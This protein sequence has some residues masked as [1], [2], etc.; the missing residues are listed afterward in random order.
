[1]Q[2]LAFG[3]FLVLAKVLAIAPADLVGSEGDA[4]S[5]DPLV[6]RI[7]QLSTSDRARLWHDL[8]DARRNS[9]RK[10]YARHSATLSQQM[11]ELFAQF[12]FI[13]EELEAVRTRIRKPR[14]L[15]PL[16]V[17]SGE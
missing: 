7:A 2:G 17:S 11:E 5:D 14:R 15:V 16:T 9:H 10:R 13:R 3:L 8:A 4:N 6:A 1:K 12:D